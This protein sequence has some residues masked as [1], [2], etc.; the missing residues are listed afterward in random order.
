MSQSTDKAI[1]LARGL[2]TR[3]RKS[4][5]AA[6]VD[7]RQAAIAETGVKA[8]IPIDR[9]FLDYV[10]HALAEAGYRRICL[11]I[12]PEHSQIRDYYNSLSLKR[13]AISY[14]IQEKPLGTANAVA[15]AESF[16]SGDDFL[17]VNS[18]NYY[19]PE[20]CAGLRQTP[21]NAVALFERDA[22]IAGSNIPADRI[23]KFAAA[24]ISPD[25][26]LT[27]ILEKPD[28]AT[29]RSLG[30]KIFVSL[31][32]WKF[33]RAIFDAC[34]AIKPSPRGE[35]EITDAVQ[36]CIDSLDQRFKALTYNS[37]VLD[38]SSRQDI[39]PVAKRLAG[40]KVEL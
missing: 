34:R 31:N 9:P 1:I 7:A 15:A 26:Y 12:G 37:A 32:C 33:S 24:L 16:S 39:A 18:D 14:A 4:D 28:E 6:S 8:L 13:I 11:V 20:A 19:P 23:V 10:M 38:M 27:R 21:G 40:T 3:M 22:L 35:Y 36:Y 25:G 2:G 30:P 5:D 17:M 29:L